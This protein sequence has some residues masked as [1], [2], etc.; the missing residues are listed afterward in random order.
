MRKIAL[1]LFICMCFA[2]MARAQTGTIVISATSTPTPIIVDQNC[3]YVVVQENVA[4]PTNQFTITLPGEPTGIVYAAGTKFIFSAGPN[5]FTRGQTIASISIASGSA[6]FI[7]IESTEV[8][9]I[10]SS[11]KGGGGGGGGTPCLDIPNSVQINNSGNFGCIQVISPDGSS[12]N[13]KGPIPWVDI[14]N[15]G[16]RPLPLGYATTGTIS[17]MSNSVSLAGAAE[18]EDGDGISIYG[19]GATNTLATP[20]APTV[21]PSTSGSSTNT[22][23]SAASPNGATTY[24]YKIRAVDGHGGVSAA[25]SAGTTT[26]GQSSLGQESATITSLA[27]SGPNVTVTMSAATPIGVGSVVTIDN[28]SNDADFGGQFLVITLTDSTHFVYQMALTNPSESATGGTAHWYNEN[29]VTWSAV[30]GAFQYAIYN[31]DTGNFIALSRPGELFFQ[32]YGSPMSDNFPRPPWIP[33]TMSGGATNDVLTTTVVSGGGTTALVLADAATNSVTSGYASFDDAPAILAAASDAKASGANLYI[34]PSVPGN[35]QYVIASPTTLPAD[36]FVVRQEGRLWLDA[37]LTIGQGVTW[38]GNLGDNQPINTFQL[39][40]G[41]PIVVNTA[42]PGIY[43][44]NYTGSLLTGVQFIQFPGTNYSL[45]MQI[46]D[47]S[48]AGMRDVSFSTGNNDTD[49]YMGIGLLLGDMVNDPF[50]I[51]LSTMSF[52]GSLAE[53]AYATTT[54]LFLDEAHTVTLNIS[55]FNRRGITISGTDPATSIQ[56][57]QAFIQGPITPFL[58]TNARLNDRLLINNLQIDTSCQPAFADWG[59]TFDLSETAQFFN[60]EGINGCSNAYVMTG[61]PIQH[62]IVNASDTLGQNHDYVINGYQSDQFTLNGSTSGSVNLQSVAAAGGVASVPN[63]TG[64][65]AETNLAQTWSAIQTFGQVNLTE[66]TAPSGT[67]ATDIFYGLTSNHW[68]AFIA[69]N[70]TARTVCGA[71]GSFTSGHIVALNTTGTICDLV[72]GGT[73]TGSGSVTTFSANSITTGTQNLATAAVANPGTTPALTFTLANAPAHKFFMNNTAGAAAP[74]YETA[75]EADLPSATVF[76]DQNATFGAHNYLFTG[77]TQFRVRASAGLTTAADGDFGLDTTNHNFHGWNNGADLLF[78]MVPIGTAVNNDC[79]KWVVVSGNVRQGDAGAAC[80][81]GG[82]G[83]TPQ[84]NGVT[85]A[86]TTGI[87]FVNTLGASGISFTNPGTTTESATIANE[88]GAGNAVATM[89]A[90]GPRVGD[91]VGYGTGPAIINITP[92]VSTNPS[93]LS[94][95]ICA[96]GSYTFVSADRGKMVVFNHSSACAVTLPQANSTGFDT[97]WYVCSKNNGVGTVTIT[98]T[99]SSINAWGFTATSL[100]LFTSMSGCIDSDNTNYSA[101]IAGPPKIGVINGTG[102]S[103]AGSGTPQNI[104]ASVPVSGNYDLYY[105]IPQSAGCTTVGSGQL[106][107]T[108]A[109]TDATTTRNSG[110]SNYTPDTSVGAADYSFNRV[111]IWAAAGTAI[112][113]TNTYT[114]CSTGT[115]TYDVHAYVLLN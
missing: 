100:P 2:S 40:G 13:I 65:V 1:A 88:T 86:T 11:V 34:P 78:P 113:L 103:T 75:G 73:G 71:T 10:P 26:T 89:T 101:N 22:G 21:T 24:H 25:S 54:P 87:N 99:T 27:K 91:Y 108:F 111:N 93:P 23:V 49:D 104:V 96:S 16:A 106:V 12:L 48:Y 112:T 51:D 110:N 19:A 102:I 50:K 64:T 63:N 79:V 98:P 28:T 18:F 32:D 74:D 66:G 5:G 33:A 52:I 92:G 95:D 105:Y 85:N 39:T 9:T 94:S 36:Q 81:A 60:I 72:D 45:E 67:S 56:I 70:G 15:Y 4:A 42:Y 97:N 30:T 35:N 62:V 82:G 29:K 47:G 38:Y 76:T 77:S 83:F 57:S 3:K 44:A 107:S 69:N 7:A 53:T 31:S 46:V 84:T 55:S 68:P 59:L 6:Q 80:G 20:S 90:T 115:W 8:P 109:W 17:A 14:T 41:S 61:N 114:A 37:T 43:S 58:A